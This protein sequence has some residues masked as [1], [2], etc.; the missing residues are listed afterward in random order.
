MGGKWGRFLIG[1]FF[2]LRGKEN[3]VLKVKVELDATQVIKSKLKIA[4]LDNKNC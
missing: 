1:Q 2:A 3:R 4:G